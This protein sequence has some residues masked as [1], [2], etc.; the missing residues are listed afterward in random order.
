MSWTPPGTREPPGA[1]GCA[2]LIDEAFATYNFHFRTVTQRAA[3]RFENRDWPGSQHDA[4]QRIE[5]YDRAVA[6]L[7]RHLHVRLGD[8]ATDRELWLATKNDYAGRTKNYLDRA[9]HETFFNSVTR[10][11]FNTVG[12]DKELEF[13][14]AHPLPA[15]AQTRSTIVRQHSYRGS[16]WRL[17]EAGLGAFHLEIPW[18]KFSAS[19]DYATSAVEATVAQHGGRY[20]LRGLEFLRPVF[21]RDYRAYLIGRLHGDDYLAPIVVALKHGDN[22]LE[23]DGLITDADE[24]SIL[25]GFARSYLHVDLDPV[26]DAVLFLKSLLPRKPLGEI[27]TALGRAKQGKTERFRSLINHLRQ[28]GDQ[29]VDAAFDKGMVMVVFTPS[30]FPVV[31]KV[32]RDRFSS[33]KTVG[34][35]DVEERYRL[36]F[37]HDRAGRLVDAQEFRDLKFKRKRFSEPVLQELSKEA[38]KTVHIEGDEVILGHVYIEREL[39]PLNRFLK[40]ADPEQQRRAVLDYGQ[41]IRDLAASNIFPGDLLLK[42]FGVTRHC[43]VIFYDYDELCLVTDCNFRDLP[44]ARTMEEEFGSQDW[45]Y[46][47]ENDVFPEQFITFLGLNEELAALFRQA[48]GELL[49]AAFW[50]DVQLRINRGEIFEILPYKRP[51]P[52]AFV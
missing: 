6:R 38:S 24:L 36:V 18:S 45:Y 16:V 14:K 9:F 41:A 44:Q 51:A 40:E 48:H 10:Q 7:V 31:L 26:R 52:H 4:V 49:T 12:V 46:V 35:R 25:V 50:R 11:I 3:G 2:R 47:A 27:Y 39:T 5:L 21:F 13:T 37:K 34:R 20:S 22:G 43:R 30:E 32:I 8:R 42:N 28:T 15:V 19:V 29:F 33:S 23:I 17:V 1:A